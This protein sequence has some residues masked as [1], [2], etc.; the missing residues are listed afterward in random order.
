[1]EKHINRA[2][3]GFMPFFIVA[4][5][6]FLFYIFSSI[7]SFYESNSVISL[8]VIIFKVLTIPTAIYLVGYWFEKKSS[9]PVIEN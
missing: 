9:K 1:M 5:A 8:P 7:N 2:K 3:N 4:S 6:V